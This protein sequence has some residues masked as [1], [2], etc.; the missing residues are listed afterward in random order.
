MKA[1]QSLVLGVLMIGPMVAMADGCP[2]LSGIYKN[3]EEYVQ[4]SQTVNLS[5]QTVYK[6]STN[7][8]PQTFTVGST[9]N[10]DGAM[11]TS[12]G[13]ITCKD[14]KL[15]MTTVL[16]AMGGAT[17]TETMSLNADGDLV[18]QQSSVIPGVPQQLPSSSTIY[19]HTN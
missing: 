3:G 11:G 14:S 18:E 7:G 12:T 1:M 19:K 13:T 10:Y 9:M 2:N 15:V 6:I 4:I 8:N 16:S 17:E 5:G